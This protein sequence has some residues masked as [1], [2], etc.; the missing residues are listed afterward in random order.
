[1]EYI[2]VI[3]VFIVLLTLIIKSQSG[4]SKQDEMSPEARAE[5]EKKKQEEYEAYRKTNEQIKLNKELGIINPQ[6]ICPH[7]QTKGHVRTKS[8]KM[9]KGISGA[10]ATGAIL[11]GGISMLATGLSRKEG[12]TQAH[13]TNC[14]STWQF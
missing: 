3:I 2:L 11:T 8:V 7:C 14:G 5:Y 13:C 12:L 9:K 10:K 4:S 1:M 6:L